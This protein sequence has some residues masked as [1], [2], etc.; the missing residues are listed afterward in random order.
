[1]YFPSGWTQQPNIKS[2]FI[3]RFYK[4]ILFLSVV[5]VSDTFTS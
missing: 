4:E 2:I 3:E 1:M 5:R